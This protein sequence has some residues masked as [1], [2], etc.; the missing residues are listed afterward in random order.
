MGKQIS[1]TSFQGNPVSGERG[2]P[3]REGG[4]FPSNASNKKFP[5]KSFTY[6]LVGELVWLLLDVF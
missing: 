6:W 4:I 2:F 5:N 1:E 3:R